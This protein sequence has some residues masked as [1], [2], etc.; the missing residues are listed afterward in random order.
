VTKVRVRVSADV[1]FG[2]TGRIMEGDECQ[3][4]VSQ[5]STTGK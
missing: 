1:W 2:I 4:S 5:T 3:R